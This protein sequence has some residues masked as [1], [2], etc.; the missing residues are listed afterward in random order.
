MRRDVELKEGER[1]VTYATNVP[2]PVSKNTMERLALIKYLYHIAVEQSRQPGILGAP[3][4]LT[5]QDGIELFLQVALDHLNVPVSGKRSPD[6]MDYWD[7][8]EGKLQNGSNLTRKNEMLRLN[9]ARVS[10]KHYGTLPSQLDVEEFRVNSLNFFEETTPVIFG[11]DFGAVSMVNV[12]QSD[13]VRLALIEAEE[14]M[15]GGKLEDSIGKI[16]VAFQ[17][18]LDYY[19]QSEEAEW[20]AEF[21]LSV[22]RSNLTTNFNIRSGGVP[23]GGNG[24][25]YQALGVVQAEFDTMR[26]TILSIE[27]KL[28]LMGLGV[29]YRRY[30]RFQRLTPY[31]FKYEG[32]TSYEYQSEQH[33]AHVPTI[34]ECRSC[35][36]FVIE[37]AI[38]V[39]EAL[40]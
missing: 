8:L 25:A 19:R 30:I 35:A 7:L 40:S 4:L 13:H 12:V 2:G 16:A 10:F 22:F 38:R 24:D 9:K 23:I 37:V 3:A 17:Q 14:L 29:D 6:F 27:N 20:D 36:S 5:L 33:P 31:V 39:Q 15:Q 18:L 34:E 11:I 21:R 32:D 28:E 26:K 1:V